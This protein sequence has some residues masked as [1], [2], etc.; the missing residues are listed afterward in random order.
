MRRA[1]LT[2]IRRAA[3]GKVLCCQYRCPD[4]QVCIE[5]QVELEVESLTRKLRL[6]EDDLED[7][8]E[9]LRTTQEQL[10]EY[11]QLADETDRCAG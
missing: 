1:P 8:R 10:H 7:S 5:L 9:R 6:M 3:A 11:T 2:T 4:S